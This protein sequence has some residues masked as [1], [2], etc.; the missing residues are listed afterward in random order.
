MTSVQLPTERAARV[1]IVD[2]DPEVVRLAQR[3]LVHDG[4][5][6]VIGVTDPIV[7]ADVARRELPDAVLLDASMPGVGGID[8]LRAL[9]ADLSTACVAVVLLCT[10]NDG[11][12]RRRAAELG[13]REF[14]AKPLDPI[15]VLESLRKALLVR[16]AMRPAVPGRAA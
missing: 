11:M 6:N 12:P 5:R 7:A 8:V 13:V 10:V 4:Y 1:M 16:A 2:D 3:Y 9:R 15:E 14:L